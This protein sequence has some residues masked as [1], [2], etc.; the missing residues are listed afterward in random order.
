M[1]TRVVISNCLD[2]F[3][4]GIVSGITGGEVVLGTIR[5]LFLDLQISQT[6]NTFR[7]A[8]RII[9]VLSGV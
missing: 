8:P 6:S 7:S 9:S 5:C 3:V 2:L 4:V 1:G